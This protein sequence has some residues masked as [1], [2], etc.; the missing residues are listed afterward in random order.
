MSLCFFWVVYPC[1]HYLC[2]SYLCLNSLFPTLFIHTHFLP[3]LLDFLHSEQYLYSEE[4]RSATCARSLYPP[5]KFHIGCCKHDHWLKWDLFSW[6]LDDS[7]LILLSWTLLS[8]LEFSQYS[9]FWKPKLSAK[10]A[11][12]KR[13]SCQYHYLLCSPCFSR[14]DL[15]FKK[16]FV[17]PATQ[18]S[19]H[20]LDASTPVWAF[21]LQWQKWD[22]HLA[23][24]VLHPQIQSSL[25]SPEIVWVSSALWL[26]PIQM[27][28]KG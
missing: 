17:T 22:H 13:H 19:F 10:W 8:G 15:C 6:N 5:G 20:P 12:W 28:S 4:D 3:H 16:Q 25:A 2:T 14:K 27:K 26:V 1:F 9:C 24:H 21:R 23:A 18:P 7:W 11:Y